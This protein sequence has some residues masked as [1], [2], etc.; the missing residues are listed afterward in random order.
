MGEHAHNMEMYDS[1]MGEH[2]NDM[3][4][5]LYDTSIGVHDSN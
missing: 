2:D 3:V 1:G 4:T 5:Y